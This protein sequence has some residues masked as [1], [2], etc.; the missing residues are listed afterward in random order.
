MAKPKTLEHLTLEQAGA[1]YALRLQLKGEEP[2]SV[3]VG[4]DLLRAFVDE[5]LS[6]L[7]D[8]T[9]SALGRDDGTADPWIEGP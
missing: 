4:P 8:E 2:L 3:A 7:G 1:A 5:A 9:R 6:L